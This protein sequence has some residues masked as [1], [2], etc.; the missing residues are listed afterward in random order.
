MAVYVLPTI[1][2]TALLWQIPHTGEH[3]KGLLVVSGMSEKN[4]TYGLTRVIV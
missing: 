3:N 4:G 1:L 2:A